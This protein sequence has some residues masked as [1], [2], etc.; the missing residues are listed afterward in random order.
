MSVLLAE[1]ARAHAGRTAIV[2]DAGEHAYDELLAA[3][4]AVAR[5]L[6]EGRA[7]LGEARVA[8]MVSPG[9]G[10]AAV[11]W[12][13]WRAGGVAVPLCLSHPEPE[14][15]YVLEDTGAAVV[16]AGPEFE[17]RLGPLARA[18][19]ARLLP[20]A[21]ALAHGGDAA[22]PRVDA[23]R[24][25][26]ILYTSG[27]TS[28]PK[29]VVTT[30]ANLRAQIEALVEA[31]EWSADDRILHVLPLH[32]THGIVNV[33]L[34]ALWV[35]AVCEMQPGFDAARVWRRL[36]ESGEAAGDRITLFMA[37]PTIY[38][39]LVAAWEAAPPEQRERWS[40]G[41]RALRLMVSGS[42]A[43]PVSTLERW[44]EISG[45]TLLERYGMTEIG[46]GLSN[47]L[48]GERRP[49]HV[50][51]PLPSVEARLVDEAGREVLSS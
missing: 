36:G 6:L 49:G 31:W 47:P 42:A 18:R 35:G 3:S 2:D 38:V 13:V 23:G 11:Q 12:G 1:R 25:A 9:F 27:T 51:R 26:M 14:L 10:Y 40:R 46:M 37:V 48:R 17:A 8:F 16:V 7:D 45:H 34:C 43:L 33:L 41:C 30:H 5:A 19:G 20:L 21:E 24:R 29:G 28:R 15:D 39:R 22:L 50:G 4:A 44:R 32:H